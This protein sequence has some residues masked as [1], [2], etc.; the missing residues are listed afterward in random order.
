MAT[1]WTNQQLDAISAEGSVIVT[2]AAG[3]GKTAVLVERVIKKLCDEINPIMADRLLIVTFTRAA[4]AEM[5]Q[6]IEKRLF[7]HFRNGFSVNDGRTEIALQQT[8]KRSVVEGHKP[9]PT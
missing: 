6:R 4:A 3:S 9:Q 5:R 7:Y 8:V 1:N 2:A